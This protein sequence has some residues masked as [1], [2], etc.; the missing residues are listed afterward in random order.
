MT[1][2]NTVSWTSDSECV[3]SVSR[4]GHAKLWKICG[5]PSTAVGRDNGLHLKYSLECLF[6]LT[7]P[8]CGGAVTCVDINSYTIVS[9][10]LDISSS[11]SNS[12]DSRRLQS[13]SRQQLQCVQSAE[14][15]AERHK[16]CF[17]LLGKC[18]II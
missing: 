8:F 10:A 5:H 3:M 18:S 4:D 11:I 6:T 14:L 16:Q 13:E 7:S 15:V 17:V 9:E 2:R 12:S 1:S